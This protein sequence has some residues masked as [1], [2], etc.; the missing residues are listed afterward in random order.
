VRDGDALVATW[1]AGGNLPPLLAVAGLLAAQGRR[2]R[3]LT[4]G[5]TRAAA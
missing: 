5:A 4:S 3:V 2:V 1:G